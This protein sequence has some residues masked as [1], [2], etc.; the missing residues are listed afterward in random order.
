MVTTVSVVVALA[1][2]LMDFCPGLCSLILSQYI[3]PGSQIATTLESDVFN[4]GAA[5]WITVFLLGERGIQNISLCEIARIEAPLAG[6]LVD[7]TGYLEV[8][9]G[10]VFNTF[11]TGV[12]DGTEY[13]EQRGKE[14]VFLA[15][16]TDETGKTILF[17]A[18]ADEESFVYEYEFL[19]DSASFIRLYE[20]FPRTTGE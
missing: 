20:R 15:A 7:A 5:A 17:P 3:H 4:E 19:G 8:D 1:L 9:S 2:R 6:F 16:G 14:F 10:I 18:C 11:R 12:Y 13:A